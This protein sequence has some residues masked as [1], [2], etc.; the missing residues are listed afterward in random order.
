MPLNCDSGLYLSHL[1]HSEIPSLRP[2][3]GGF[4]P[5]DLR[6]L[7]TTDQEDFPGGDHPS[8]MLSTRHVLENS[9]TCRDTCLTDIGGQIILA[10]TFASSYIARTLPHERASNSEFVTPMND[11]YPNPE[12]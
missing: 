6:Y 7:N 12:R 8:P 9:K 5:K 3:H 4:S 2:G 1:G 10:T 11:H